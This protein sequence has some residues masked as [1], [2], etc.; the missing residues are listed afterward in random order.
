MAKVDEYIAN[1]DLENSGISSISSRPSHQ[2]T[3]ISYD[4]EA[5]PEREKL[6]YEINRLENNA[7]YWNKVKNYMRQT[8]V[9]RSVPDLVFSWEGVSAYC[10]KKQRLFS[11]CYNSKQKE[12][13][14]FDFK[15]LWNPKN[16]KPSKNSYLISN[17]EN[18]ITTI[19]YKTSA[20]V[21]DQSIESFSS[22]SSFDSKPNF[23]QVLNNGKR[24]TNNMNFYFVRL[25]S[26]YN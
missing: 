17:A 10:V 18:K 9:V 19:S 14:G 6:E 3:T 21:E 8:K 12:N 25:K 11:N 4:D 1:Y 2:E 16:Q 20:N 5:T 7:A 13:K 22:T 23:Y 15:K 24:R 26:I